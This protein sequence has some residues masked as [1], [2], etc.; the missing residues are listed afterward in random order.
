MPENLMRST[1][2]RLTLMLG[3]AFVLALVITGAVAHLLVRRELLEII[4]QNVADTYA[5][6]AQTYG[7]GELESLVGSVDS[8]VSATIEQD[9]VY[10]LEDASGRELAGNLDGVDVADGWST[11]PPHAADQLSPGP[12]YRVFSGTVAGYRLAV[13]MNLDEVDEIGGVMLAALGWAGAGLT[14]VVAG[15]GVMIALRGQ[16]RL[17]QISRT[18]ADVGRG[19]LL[20]RISLGRRNDDIDR[21]GRDVNTAL[22]RLAALVEGMRQVSVDIAHEL[23]TPLNR[24]GIAIEA[25]L[26]GNQR[27]N[28]VQPLLEQ[29]QA[30]GHTINGTFDALL[31]IAQIES[32]AR[33]ARFTQLDLTPILETIAEAYGAVA[34][35]RRQTLTLRL[36]APLAPIH[37]D[38]DLLTQL[39]ANLVENA[40]RHCSDEAQIEIDAAS[41]DGATVVTVR[42]TGPGIPEQE[43]EKVFQRLYRLEKSRTTSGSGLGLALVKAIV[44]LHGARITLDD[45]RPG[46]VVRIAF[47]IASRVEPSV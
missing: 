14:L 22:D 2:A 7:D 37:G 19:N 38:A 40:I 30:E 41:I 18:M 46:L 39:L 5:T 15:T 3:A 32:G 29:A 1:P 21:I 42:D 36:A 26:E 44:E 43:R 31:R 34:A 45:N 13:G 9:R 16:R 27:G 4:D 25:A 12:A 47:P 23:K 6:I 10:L 17:E 11:I 24:L 33:R 20:A 35:D 28:D 8:H